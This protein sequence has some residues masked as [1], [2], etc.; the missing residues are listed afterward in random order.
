MWIKYGAA[1]YNVAALTSIDP[2]YDDK[3]RLFA[4][5]LYNQNRAVA[6]LHFNVPDELRLAREVVTWIQQANAEAAQVVDTYIA[7]V[8]LEAFFRSDP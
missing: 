2:R 7:S 6:N 3:G 4:V 5:V 8:D 1:H